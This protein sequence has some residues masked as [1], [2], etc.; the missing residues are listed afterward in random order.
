MRGARS[1]TVVVACLVFAS[2]VEAEVKLAYIDSEVLRQELP[3]FKSVERQLERLKQ[4]FEQ[5]ATERESKLVR[6]K[7][8]FRKQELLMS[9][10]RKA[11]MQAQFEESLRQ[12]QEYAQ[13]KFGTNG[14]I[15]RKNVELSSP[16]LERINAAIEAIA[17]EDGYDFIFDV[18]NSGA[19]V[20]VDPDRYNVTTKLL[21]Y[22]QKEREEREKGRQ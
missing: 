19:I 6:L 8:D 20:Y 2:A 12:L 9:E 11:E 1:L 13:Q 5:E 4:Q 15:F 18:A 14:E 22:L 21:D 10:T 3:E 17:K 7:D 16:I